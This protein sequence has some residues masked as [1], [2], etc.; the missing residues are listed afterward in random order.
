[1][2]GN[3]GPG[4]SNPI[5]GFKYLY[6]NQDNEDEKILRWKDAIRIGCRYF[7]CGVAGIAVTIIV[8]IIW[9]S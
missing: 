1:M 4:M 5:R 3:L 9:I 6:S 2:I 8:I 7:L